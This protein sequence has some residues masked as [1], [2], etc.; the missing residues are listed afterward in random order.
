M[1]VLLTHLFFFVCFFV[2]LLSQSCNN[3]FKTVREN[4]EQV[5]AATE[6]TK[7]VKLCLYILPFLRYLTSN[8]DVVLKSGPVSFKVTENDT[9]R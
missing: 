2:C 8:N 4:S 6:A 9:I 5:L 7:R 3:I 1:S